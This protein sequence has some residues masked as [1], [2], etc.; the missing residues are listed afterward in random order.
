MTAT[1]L[2]L[3]TGER[4]RSIRAITTRRPILVLCLVAIGLTWSLQMGLVLAGEDIFPGK[5]AELIL[6]TGTA[7]LM[8]GLIGGRGGIRRLFAGLT[9]WRIGVTRWLLVLFAMP[10]VALGIAVVTGTLQAPA[11]G[12]GNVALAYFAF[13]LLI[14][15]AGSIWEETA[16]AGFV[17]TRLIARSGLLVGSVLTSVPFLLIHLPLAY[18]AEGWAA[19]SWQETFVAWGW[20]LAASPFFRYL[21]GM[22]LV[23]TRGSVLAVA[24]MHASFNATGTMSVLQPA[25]WQ[26]VPALATLTVA[27]AGGRWFLRRRAART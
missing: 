10:V 22:L 25:G 20:L 6:L 8:A 18:E 4:K 13:L 24:L 21:A 27:V 15:I 26:Y 1:Q 5:I 2:D 9:R 11:G 7:T 19:T 16:W 23:D 17:Q 3:P 12:W 14:A